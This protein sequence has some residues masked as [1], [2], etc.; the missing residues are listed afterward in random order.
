MAPVESFGACALLICVAGAIAAPFQPTRGLVVSRFFVSL[1][2][3]LAAALF[4]RTELAVPAA[5]FVAGALLQQQPVVSALRL[6]QLVVA[7]F[8]LAWWSAFFLPRLPAL[9]PLL[10]ADSAGNPAHISSL[11]DAADANS[12]PML[13]SLCFAIVL[14]LLLFRMSRGRARAH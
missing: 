2:V 11:L 13:W 3:V 10:P 8:V 12:G 1:M 5:V 14:V 6:S 7:A 4:Y 9:I